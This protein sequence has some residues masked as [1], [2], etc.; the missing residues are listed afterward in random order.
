MKQYLFNLALIDAIEFCKEHDIDP[1]GT[2]L[3]KYPRR[4]TYALVR[5]TDSRALITTTF[6]KSQVPTHTIHPNT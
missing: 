6:H 1:S 2:H 3:Y 5:D 4:Q